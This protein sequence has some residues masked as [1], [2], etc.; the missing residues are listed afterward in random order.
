MKA[1]RLLL[2]GCFLSLLK[3]IQPSGTKTGAGEALHW[4]LGDEHPKA[5]L[6]FCHNSNSLTPPLY[7]NGA[8]KDE[9]G[10]EDGGEDDEG[11]EEGEGEGGGGEM[12]SSA[13]DSSN[14]LH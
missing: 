4:N 8:D 12:E 10:D 1:A 2:C 14:A 13:D 6:K 11:G 9:A 3:G 5:C 7:G